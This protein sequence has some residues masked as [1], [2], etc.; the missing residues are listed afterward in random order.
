MH[1]EQRLVLSV[2]SN[3][4]QSTQKVDCKLLAMASLA[5]WPTWEVDSIFDCKVTALGGKD[6]KGGEGGGKA[7]SRKAPL[8]LYV[9]PFATL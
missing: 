6:T 1:C 5:S 2:D 7:G 3:W 4:H 9:Q 8:G